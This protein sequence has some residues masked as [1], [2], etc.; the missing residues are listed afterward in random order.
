MSFGITK[1]V[2]RI[3][4]VGVGQVGGAV[5]YAL[6]PTSIASELLLVDADVDLRDGQV[7]DL[8]D[9]AY[10]S[11]SGTRV[12]A[13]T[14]HEAGQCDVVVITAGSKYTL[15]QTSIESTYRNVSI[16]R[17]VVTAMSPFKPETILL[18]VANPVDLLTS[19]AQ[20]LARLPASQVLGSG[21]FL[22][23]V[24][25]RGLMADRTGVAANSIDVYVLG[26]HGDSQVVAWSTATIGG[27]PI[28][29]SHLPKDL[30]NRVQ[31]ADECKYRS[32]SIIRAKG[33]TPF[34]IGSIVSSICSSILLDKR[35]VRPISHFQP[36]FGCCF[37]LPVVLGRK[38]II[39]TI[40][41]PLDSDEEA[42][43]AESARTVR[44][45]MDRVRENE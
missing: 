17:N 10:S 42:E 44:S 3:A 14:Y 40:Q 15:G 34:G 4:I 26:V 41:M 6:I 30:I 43:I 39:S 24:R 33:A 37:S 13:A 45:L 11:N 35:N 28:D 21:T 16:V 5:A 7:R 22:D 31:L 23:S 1:P 18:V 36:E 12:R 2:S 38:G 8:S 32:Q 29:K 25:L 19:L 9:V 20:N 27:V